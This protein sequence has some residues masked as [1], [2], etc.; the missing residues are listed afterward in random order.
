LK[1][2][3]KLGRGHHTLFLWLW[4]FVVAVYIVGGWAVAGKGGR[5]DVL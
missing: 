1:A 4:T 3:G 2:K 5:I